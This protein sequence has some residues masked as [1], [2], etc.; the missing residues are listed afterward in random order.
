M[1]FLYSTCLLLLI[2]TISSTLSSCDKTKK[3]N[4]KID[5]VS[6]MLSTGTWH[7][8]QFTDDG[9]DELSHFSGYTFTFKSSGTVVVDNGIN[10]YVGSWSITS[11]SPDDSHDLHLNMQFNYDNYFRDLNED[12]EFISYET[13]QMALKHVSGGNGGTDYLTFNKY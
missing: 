12:W 11:G 7:I 8:V 2:L 5:D 4:Q 6:T 10:N 13:I 1:K 3:T 9:A